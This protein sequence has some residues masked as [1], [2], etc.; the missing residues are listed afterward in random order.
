MKM[1]MV[2]NEARFTDWPGSMLVFLNFEGRPGKFNAQGNRTFEIELPE[3]EAELLSNL[4]WRVTAK[5]VKDDTV[6]KLKVKVN[7]DGRVPPQ[8]NRVVDG[9]SLIRPLKPNVGGRFDISIIDRESRTNAIKSADITLNGWKNP[10]DGKVTAFLQY[11]TFVCMENEVIDKYA[12]YTVET[13]D[14]EVPW[15]F[16]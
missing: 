1:T 7:Y 9:T 8:V 12:N 6:Y 2:G 16:A 3:K 15:R 13:D 14:G 4:G 11:A 5:E 10:N